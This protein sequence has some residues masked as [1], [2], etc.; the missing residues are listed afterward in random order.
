MPSTQEV[1]IR[2]SHPSI[3]QAPSEEEEIVPLDDG[4]VMETHNMAYNE[5]Q[6]NIVQAW[7]KHFP[8]D[9]ASLPFLKERVIVRNTKRNLGAIA[10]AN[11]AFAS[12]TKSNTE[13]LMAKKRQFSKNL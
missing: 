8:D 2:S 9:L 10:I 4:L 12:A 6:K 5:L 7:K 13:Y 11:L 3:E 1:T